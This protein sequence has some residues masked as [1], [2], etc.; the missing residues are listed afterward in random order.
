MEIA[1]ASCMNSS[2]VKQQAVW[3][4]VAAEQ[5]NVLVL[6]GD[7]IYLDVPWPQ[8]VHPRAMQEFEFIEHGR[9]LYAAQLAIAGF[10]DLVRQTPTHAIWDDH[11]FLWNESYEEK[12]IRKKIYAKTIRASRALFNC[13][14]EALEA[15]L[16]GDP[17]PDGPDDFRLW[18]PDEPAP[19]YR[20]RDLG[21]GIALHLTDGRSWRVDDNLLGEQQ[22][23]DIA[24]KIASLPPQTI[25]LLASGSVVA[26]EKGDRWSAF[27]A[28]FDW[29]K[30]LAKGRRVLVLSGDI[31]D[32]RIT[33]IDLGDE[34]WLFDAT[35]SGAAVP[36][37][38]AAAGPALVNFG[39]VEVDGA[40]VVVT[41]HSAGQQDRPP[42]RIDR[43]Q[44]RVVA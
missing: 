14:C 29:L 6:L 4:H 13:Y 43:A 16:A 41:C 30:S 10:A 12:A 24:A 35:S 34:H 19:G 3:G 8:G 44:W 38:F 15:R 27:A 7:S 36:R 23:R 1:F 9:R 17:F 42:L 26:Q 21:E 11:D 33:S 39:I 18:Q 31:H 25:H 22:R 32:N 20:Y 5:P 40:S 28:D 37:V 2:L